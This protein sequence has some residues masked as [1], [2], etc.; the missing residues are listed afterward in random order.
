MTSTSWAGPPATSRINGAELTTNDGATAGTTTADVEIDGSAA[1]AAARIAVSRATVD[2]VVKAA[3]KEKFG[4]TVI[5]TALVAPDLLRISITGATVQGRLVIDASG[6]IA[7]STP[8]GS[9]PI[10]RLDPSF[11]L[12][13]TAVHVVDGNLQVDA[14]LDAQALLGG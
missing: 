11:P 14:T 2:Q 1:S 13:L 6:A 9:A 10:L 4:V 3:M 12:R 7:L 8:L 5:S